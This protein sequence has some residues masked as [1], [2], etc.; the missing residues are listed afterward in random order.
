MSGNEALAR[1]IR[2]FTEQVGRQPTSA[3]ADL[4][5]IID[6]HDLEAL[7]MALAD[8]ASAVE[9]ET[10]RRERAARTRRVG[11]EE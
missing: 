3:L 1:I 10:H 5:K 2:Q 4:I 8:L 11:S 7:R 6:S 9:L